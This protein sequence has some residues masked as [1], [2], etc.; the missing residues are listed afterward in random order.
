MNPVRK[1]M[2]RSEN[3]LQ[4]GTFSGADLSNRA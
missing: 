1:S 4:I 2:L 3:Y